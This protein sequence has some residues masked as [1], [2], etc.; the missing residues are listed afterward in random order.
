MKPVQ[1]RQLKK[2][3]INNAHRDSNKGN[4]GQGNSGQGNSDQGNS[5]RAL[6]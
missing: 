2:V 5:A 4:S 1:I 3:E 6:P